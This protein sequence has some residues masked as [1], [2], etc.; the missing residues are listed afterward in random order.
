MVVPKVSRSTVVSQVLCV[1]CWVAALQPAVRRYARRCV[2][3]IITF[4]YPVFLQSADLCLA[5]VIILL[6]VLVL[7]RKKGQCVCVCVCVRVCVYQA[8]RA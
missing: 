4:L 6:C 5:H 8:K 3:F 1:L 7:L 2:S